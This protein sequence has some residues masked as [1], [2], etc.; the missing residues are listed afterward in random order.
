MHE[1]HEFLLQGY[2]SEDLLSASNQNLEKYV[3]FN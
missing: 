1:N 2:N 3:I